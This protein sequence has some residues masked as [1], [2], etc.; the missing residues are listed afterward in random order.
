MVYVPILWAPGNVAYNEC[1]DVD[2]DVDDDDDYDDAM[3]M[4]MMILGDGWMSTNTWWWESVFQGD[5]YNDAVML[6]WPIEEY[7]T[8]I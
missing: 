6:R 2:Y 3:M 7:Q 1:F 8:K 5:D 4:M